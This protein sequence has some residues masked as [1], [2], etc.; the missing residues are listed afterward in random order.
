[1]HGASGVSNNQIQ[2]AIDAG[3]SKIN[4]YSYL[5]TAVPPKLAEHINAS[6]ERIFYHDLAL[7]AQEYIKELG[8][9][10]LK[11]FMNN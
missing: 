9:D 8:K 6:K 3:I 10:T 5:S 7:L 4:Y 11:V 2:Q 1:M